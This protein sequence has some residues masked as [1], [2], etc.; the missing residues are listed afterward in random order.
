MNSIGKRI[1]ARYIRA[2]KSSKEKIAVLTCADFITAKILDE[3]GGCEVNGFDMFDTIW[4]WR[5]PTAECSTGKG[6][7]VPYSK[8]V[9]AYVGIISK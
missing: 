5:T 7:C 8:W 9:E 4:F 3:A 2:R 1:T 6:G